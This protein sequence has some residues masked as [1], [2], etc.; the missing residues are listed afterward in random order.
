MKTIASICAV[1]LMTAGITTAHAG[2]K[3]N[4]LTIALSEPIDGVAEFFASSDESQLHSRAVYDRLLSVDHE[5]SKILPLLATSWKQIDTTTWELNLRDDVKFHDGSKFDADDVV[6][7]LNWASDPAVKLRLK[8]RFSWISKA[9]KLSPTR[10]RIKTVEPYATTLL[11]LAIS[12]PIVPSDYH[13]SFQKKEDFEYKPVGT[14]TYRAVSVDRNA[15]I[16]LEA[17][18]DYPQASS[19]QPKPTIGKIVIKSIPD[20]QTRIAQMLVDAVD[21]T[22]VV[23]TDVGT[24]MKAD[25]RF[26]ITTVNGLQY[27]YLYLDAADRSGGGV[28]KNPKVRQAIAHAIDRD[29]IRKEIIPGGKDAFEMKALCIPFQIG[30]SS[31]MPVPA[32]DPAKAK[33]L[34]KEA[35][36]ENGFDLE[37]TA[38]DRSR[39]AAEAISGY[40]SK[41]G[42]RSTIKTITF[43]AYTKLQAD[44]KFQGLVHI[45]GS[46]GVPDTG[47]I[48]NFHFNNKIRD[49]AHDARINE[50]GDRIETLFDEGERNKLIREAMDINNRQSYVIPLSGAP[51]AFVHTVDL[52]VPTT[53]L[54]GYGIVLSALAWK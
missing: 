27:F 53:T 12:V 14:G 47:Q 29:E 15:G 20:E 54:N 5:K 40:L 36:Y 7:T 23:T 51:Q 8:N 26:T 42:I 25:R 39:P 30:C 34:M 21:L 13:G 35:G 52:V 38:L 49:Y 22:R 41:I 50:I 2:S 46:G 37:L 31:S 33:A 32:Y 16:V 28:L 6:Y 43:T 45:Y 1:T 19:A 9:E 4:S 24:Q 11:T 3:N 44:G 18:P 48:V 10:V 17:N